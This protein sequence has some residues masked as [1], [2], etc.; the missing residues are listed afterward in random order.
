MDGLSFSNHFARCFCRSK[1]SFTFLQ[2]YFSKKQ[3]SFLNWSF[4]VGL[5]E[6]GKSH[7]YLVVFVVFL[8]VILLSHAKNHLISECLPFASY[9]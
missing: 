6:R 7:S 8:N 9:I 5:A 1:C 2:H 4:F 3:Q